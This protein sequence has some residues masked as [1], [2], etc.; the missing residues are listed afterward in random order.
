[1]ASLS[2]PRSDGEDPVSPRVVKRI[3]DEVLSLEPAERGPYLDRCLPKGDLVR[4]EVES[5]LDESERAREL[6]SD[7]FFDLQAHPGDELDKGARIGAYRVVEQIG[8]G[9]MGTVY[10]ACRADDAFEKRVAVKVV[11][12]ALTS[13]Q[14]FRRFE[15]ERQNLA[16]LEHGHIARLLDGGSTDDR[17]PYLVMEHVDGQ[18]IDSYCDQ[19]RLTLRQRLRLFQKVCRAVHHAHQR[20]V[21][22]AD[23]KPGNILVTSEGTPKLLDF[24]I[25]SAIVGRPAEAYEG[26]WRPPRVNLLTPLFASPEQHV[27]EILSTTADVY[28]L[29]VLLQRLCCG[30]AVDEGSE[31]DDISALHR[32]RLIPASERLKSVVDLPAVAQARGCR[33]KVLLRAVRGDLDAILLKAVALKAEDRYDSVQELEHEIDRHLHSRP[34]GVRSHSKLYVFRRFLNRHRLGSAMAALALVSLLTAMVAVTLSWRAAVEAREEAERQRDL[35]QRV[36]G[37][38]V[39]LFEIPDPGQAK[40]K[41][42]TAREVLD[43]GRRTIAEGLEHEPMARAELLETMVDS[44]EGLGL[45]EDALPL[46]REAFAIRSRWL[47]PED[48]ELAASQLELASV[49]YATGRDPEAESLMRRA[50]TC[51]ERTA[52]DS[53]DLVKGR[54]NLAALMARRGDLEEAEQLYRQALEI[55]RLATGTESVEMA[56]GL[57]NLGAVLIRRGRPGDALPLLHQALNIRRRVRGSPHPETALTLSNIGQALE[58]IGD[59]EGS[60]SYNEDAAAMRRLLY[61]DGHPALLATL[62]NTGHLFHELGRLDEAEAL[63]QEALAHAESRLGDSHP[64]TAILRR[65]LAAVLVDRGQYEPAEALVR[66][67]IAGFEGNQPGGW[68]IADARSVLGACLAG[69]GRLPEAEPLLSEG[70]T[71]LVKLRGET[72]KQARAARLRLL[73][74]YETVGDRERAA[75]IWP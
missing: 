23:L 47:D 64:N 35:A 26:C 27:G 13:E 33:P 36:Q 21:I 3:L 60:L 28:A 18:A 41:K 37:F 59:L 25:S 19:R 11:R 53:L 69:Q 10:A 56:A 58:Q 31:D 74:Y 40:G 12:R 30:P 75:S 43:R 61:E 65:N 51:L 42:V 2:R 14:A 20:G 71:A 67:A 34:L 5:L 66:Q 52:P 45:Y 55:K 7:P 62:N 39:Q 22:H 16:D 73:E 48:P 70:Y 54:N 6:F 17:L 72:S 9:G 32:R 68:R 46:A 38:L 63:L 8:Y 15:V 1:M 50:I 44:Y 4:L 29:G 49:L 57:N 24:G